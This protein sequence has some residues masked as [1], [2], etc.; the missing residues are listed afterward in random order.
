MTCPAVPFIPAVR[1]ASSTSRDLPMP[2]GSHHAA[3][4]AGSRQS[5]LEKVP[6]AVQS[7]VRHPRDRVLCSSIPVVP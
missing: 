2:K 1:K 3:D 6:H 4:S 7:I 5:L